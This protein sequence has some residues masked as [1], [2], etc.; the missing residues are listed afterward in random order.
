M[1]EFWEGFTSILEMFLT[2]RMLGGLFGA[3]T[4]VVAAFGTIFLIY[5][6]GV[7]AEKLGEKAGTKFVEWQRGK[8]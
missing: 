7:Y 4:I 1:T 8:Q 5:K 2:A 3:V 6:L